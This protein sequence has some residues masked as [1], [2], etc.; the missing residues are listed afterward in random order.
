[1]VATILVQLVEA[2][3]TGDLRAFLDVVEA[4]GMDPGEYPVK[5]EFGRVEA[6]I[7]VDQMA[8]DI[9]ADGP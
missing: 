3:N 8:M 5:V 9:G 4:L 1:M 2:G 6:V 7:E